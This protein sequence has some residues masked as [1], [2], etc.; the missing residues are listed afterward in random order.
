MKIYTKGV[1]V[2]YNNAIWTIKRLIEDKDGQ[3]QAVLKRGIH[4]CKAPIEDLQ[5]I[6]E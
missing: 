5:S 4:K 6:S 1:L 2:R 3:T